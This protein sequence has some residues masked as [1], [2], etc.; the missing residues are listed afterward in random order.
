MQFFKFFEKYFVFVF[1]IAIA[2]GF[3]FRQLAGLYFI[4]PFVFSI[5]IFLASLKVDFRLLFEQLKDLK[6]FAEKFFIIRIIAPLLVFFITS[7]IVPEFALGALLVVAL[8]CGMINIIFSDIFKGNNALTLLFTVSTHL[9]SPIL[10]PLLVFL[11]SFQ[12][13]GFDYAGLFLSLA[14]IVLLPVAAAYFIKKNFEGVVQKAS[15]NLSGLNILLVASTVAIIIAENASKLTDHYSFIW[16]VLYIAV[17]YLTLTFFGFFVAKNES[18]ENR[19]AI[20]L[21]AWRTNLSLGLVIASL[22]FPIS[23]LSVIIAA[24]LVIDTYTALQKIIIGKFL[25][26]D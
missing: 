11:V 25:A 23:V 12:V 20:S 24:E 2:V 5:A 13:V 4:A 26:E 7:L 6:Y 1:L 16:Q 10:I 22:Y 8:P 9:L 18:R 19:I 21:S 14:Q 3:L 17:L 15:P